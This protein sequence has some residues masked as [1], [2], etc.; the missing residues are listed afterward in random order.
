MKLILLGPFL[1]KGRNYIFDFLFGKYFLGY[2]LF[3]KLEKI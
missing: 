1:L 3:Y 2:S